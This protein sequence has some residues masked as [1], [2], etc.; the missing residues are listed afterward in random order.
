MREM[1]ELTF[2]PSSLSIFG[3]PTEKIHKKN[4]TIEYLFHSN[5]FSPIIENNLVYTQ[6]F[7]R[8]IESFVSLVE[9]GKNEVSMDLKSARYTYDLLRVIQCGI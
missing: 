5:Q 2:E 8:E 1:E 3:I 7:Y 6:G 9:K 4:K